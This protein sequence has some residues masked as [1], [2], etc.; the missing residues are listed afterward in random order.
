MSSPAPQYSDRPIVM[1]ISGPAGSGKTTLCER[2]TKDYPR[3]QRLV[4]TTSRA[5]RRGEVEG[6]DYHFL[7]PVEF[8]QGIANGDF[9]EWAKVHDRFYGSQRCHVLSLLEQ[10]KD[11]LLNIDVQGAAAFRQ[12]ARDRDQF[13]G[14]IHTV[15]IKPASWEQIRQRLVSRGT[16]NEDEIKRRLQSAIAEIESAADFDHVIVSGTREEDYLRLQQLY[17]RLRSPA[18]DSDSCH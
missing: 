6:R 7:T 11:I 3:I 18:G 9:I 2:L 17:L 5:P 10:G 14:R 4:T 13:R 1:V 12:L 15:F 16:D 8:E